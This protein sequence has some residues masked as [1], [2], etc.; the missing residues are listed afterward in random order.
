M[1]VSTEQLKTNLTRP[2]WV[3][4]DCRHDLTDHARGANLYVDGHIAGAYF[5]PVETVLA[6]GK[7]GGNGRHPLPTV[8]S[9]ANFFSLHGI[10]DGTQ[11]VAYDD[12]GG[13]Y[14]ARFW[15]LARWVGLNRVAVLDGGL[16]KWIAD[17]NMLVTET[18]RPRPRTNFVARPDDSMHCCV[19]DVVRGVK[20]GQCCVIDARA[21][22]RYRGEIEPIDKVAGH[23]PSAINRFFKLNLHADLTMRAPDEL[24]REFSALLGAR[25]PSAVVHQC[26]SGIT[27]CVNLLAMERAGL[28]GSKLYVGSWSEWSADPSRPVERGITSSG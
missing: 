17:G 12:V 8:E 15:W 1:V 4:F 25:A 10:D 24:R 3:V 14:A 20:T 26:G 22:E 13:Q 9:L 23:I 28:R 21:P 18:P 5:A 7:N 27:A 19:D 16:P 11:V 6:G 2:D